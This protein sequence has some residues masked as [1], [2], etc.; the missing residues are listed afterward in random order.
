MNAKFYFLF[1][2]FL[3]IS[4]DLPNEADVDC[5]GDNRG[6]AYIDDCGRC[7]DG[8][9][10]YNEGHDK[11]ACNECFGSNACLDGLCVDDL[12]IN[13]HS[14]LP[15]NAIGDNS[16]C[17]YDVCTDYLPASLGSTE[18]A[19][20]SDGTNNSVYS[21][22]EQ[23]RCEDI[24]Q[25]YSICYPD[26][27][28]TTFKLADFYGKAIWIEMTS[29]WWASCYTKISGTDSFIQEYLDEPN[30]IIINYFYDEYQPYSCVQWGAEGNNK[31]PIMINDGAFNASGLDRLFYSYPS[32]SAP[33]VPKHIFIDKNM[34]V[35][36]KQDTSMSEVEIKTKIDEMLEDF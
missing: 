35:Y 26:N 9:T 19:C 2:C 36:Y 23:L 25:D 4:C 24:E 34:V 27:C 22:G 8:Q 5:N 3:I 28:D 32:G 18:Y 20:N 15:G 6:M 14:D 17:I 16:L 11:D 30:L 31:L 1:L 12:A 7:V 21:I 29:S 13:Y 10:G 33:G